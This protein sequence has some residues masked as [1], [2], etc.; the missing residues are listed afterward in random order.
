MSNSYI[1]EGSYGCVIKPGIK[2]KKNIK[3]TQYPNFFLIKK[4]GFM[5]LIIIK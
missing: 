1:N 5:K 3:K 2:C 4:H